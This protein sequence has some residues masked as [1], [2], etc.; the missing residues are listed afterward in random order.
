MDPQSRCTELAS[1]FCQCF[2]R[3][4]QQQQQTLRTN[5]RRGSSVRGSLCSIFK[6][7]NTPHSITQAAAAAAARAREEEERQQRAWELE[8]LKLEAIMSQAKGEEGKGPSL[9]GLPGTFQAPSRCVCAF[10]DFCLE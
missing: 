8:Q 3:Q 5:E 9:L 4:Q 2:R 10:L 6:I 7:C 1:T